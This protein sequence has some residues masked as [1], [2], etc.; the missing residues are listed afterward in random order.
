MFS[1]S[2]TPIAFHAYHTSSAGYNTKVT[3]KFRGVTLNEGDHYDPNTGV[4]TC[5]ADGIYVFTVSLYSNSRYYST[6]DL[7]HEGE[8]QARAYGS[9]GD[10][11]QGTVT[12]VLRCNHGDEVWVQTTPEQTIV[13]YSH[14]SEKL[15]VFSGFLL[16]K[17]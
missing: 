7:V 2:A 6:V 9:A 3:V 14:E 5:P 17:I 10:A 15:G 4:F 1:E 12:A 16:Y 13:T 8:A 11:D